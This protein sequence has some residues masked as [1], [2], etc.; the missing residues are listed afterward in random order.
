PVCGKCPHTSGAALLSGQSPAAFQF[1][2]AA[3]AMV[4]SA[5]LDEFRG[6]GS[7][8]IGSLG[9]IIR[10]FIPVHAQPLHSLENAFDHFGRRALQIG[11]FDSENQRAT[12]MAGE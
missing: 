11:V 1:V 5:R 9:L 3:E 7:V 8:K 12:E 6:G 4:S 2:F 10:A